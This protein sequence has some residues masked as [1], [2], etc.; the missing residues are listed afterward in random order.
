[1]SLIRLNHTPSRQQQLVF[2]TAWTVFVGG[3]GVVAWAKGEPQLA[4]ILLIVA[5]VLPLA[6]LLFPP[7]LR[8]SYVLLSYITYPIGFVVSHVVLA[9]LYYLVFTPVGLIMRLL[10]YD[11]LTRRLDPK[12]ASYWQ[13]RPKPGPAADYFRQG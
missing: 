2:G 8:W 6:G 3:W 13:E 10:R 4:G 12:A 9:I 11:P 7:L 5:G 1:M